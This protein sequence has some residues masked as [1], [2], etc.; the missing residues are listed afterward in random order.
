LKVHIKYFSALREITQVKEE[1]VDVEEACTLLDV[2]RSISD[3]HG[4]NV[5]K[6]LF[7]S[8]THEPRSHLVFFV[9]D[10]PIS[11]L[12]GFATTVTSGCTVAIIPP[13][14]GG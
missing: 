11:E 8:K 1:V 4:E 10:T 5:T 13:I 7:D 2:L 3:K 9:G 12:N 14:G 6:Y